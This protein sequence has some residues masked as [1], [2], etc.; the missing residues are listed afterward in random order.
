MSAWL[1]GAPCAMRPADV[2]KRLAVSVRTVYTLLETRQ[3]GFIQ[4]GGQY[5]IRHSDLEAYE[6][7]QWHAPVSSSRDTG[8]SSAAVVSMSGGG[9]TAGSAFQ[10]GQQIAAKLRSS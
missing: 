8:S 4:V 9:K 2:A 1:D 7:R 6:A 3:L 10:R 5:R